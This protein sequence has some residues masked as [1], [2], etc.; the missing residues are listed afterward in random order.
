MANILHIDAS[1]RQERSFSRNLT[2]EVVTAWQQVH[3]T[4]SL[5]ERLRQRVDYLDLGHRIVPP[6]DEA[7]I[8]AAFSHGDRTPEMQLGREIQIP[9]SQPRHKSCKIGRLPKG[10]KSV[11]LTRK[12]ATG[13]DI[14][15]TLVADVVAFCSY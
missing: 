15:A 5:A 11:V 8:A 14:M 1:P 2:Q 10:L 7:W 9:S 13:A 3:P 6:V 4:D 12:I